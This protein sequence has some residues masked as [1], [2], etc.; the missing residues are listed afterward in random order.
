MA[1]MSGEADILAV[2]LQWRT[3]CATNAFSNKNRNCG[4][5]LSQPLESNVWADGQFTIMPNQRST[6]SPQYGE[7]LKFV[8]QCWVD[9]YR[10]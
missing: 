2:Y 3:R 10:L 4:C 9:R 7:K 6:V 5:R 1:V 8:T